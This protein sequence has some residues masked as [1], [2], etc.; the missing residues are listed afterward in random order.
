M[1]LFKSLVLSSLQ[2][3]LKSIAGREGALCLRLGNVA[4]F[5][6][7][8]CAIPLTCL[9]PS[10]ACPSFVVFFTPI[11]IIPRAEEALGGD[12]GHAAPALPLLGAPRSGTPVMLSSLNSP[13]PRGMLR[14]EP[15]SRQAVRAGMCS[16]GSL[17]EHTEHLSPRDRTAGAP[18]LWHI[19]LLCLQFDLCCCSE[20]RQG[21][22]WE[23]RSSSNA[24][25]QEHVNLS[26]G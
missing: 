19:E 15:W 5:G 24:M 18:R 14:M 20:T 8:Q 7:A 4:E 13:H 2:S 10:P 22:A 3:S 1:C 16:P 11:N 12:V 9:L 17:R 6:K 21:K 26:A 25:Q 23:L